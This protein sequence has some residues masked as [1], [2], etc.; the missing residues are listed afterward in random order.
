M[1]RATHQHQ[2][3]IQPI[4]NRRGI[5]LNNRL[6]QQSA[7]VMAACGALMFFISFA[8]AFRGIS[9]AETLEMEQEI[10]GVMNG[11]K[12]AAAREAALKREPTLL[13]KF[14]NW[15]GEFFL[16]ALLY[17]LT[18]HGSLPLQRRY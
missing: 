3:T 12:Y 1:K 18:A 6:P 10:S 16:R 11:P 2:I 9:Q 4:A 8:A 14:S 17:S 5:R 7:A 15:F 13:S